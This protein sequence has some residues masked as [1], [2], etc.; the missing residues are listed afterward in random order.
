MP[1]IKAETIKEATKKYDKYK[2]VPTIESLIIIE[3]VYYV[4]NKYYYV[5]A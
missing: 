3:N 1:H 4:V 2:H 5:R